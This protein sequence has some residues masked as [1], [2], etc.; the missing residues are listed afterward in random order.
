MVFDLSYGKKIYDWYGRHPLAYRIGSWIVFLGRERTLRRKGVELVGLHPGETVLDLAC[1]NGVNFELLQ[2]AV[3]AGGRIIG[4]DYSEGMLGFAAGRV[5]RAGWDNVRLVQGDAA[6]LGLPPASIDGAFCSL[7]LSAMPDHAAAIRS[8]HRELK[9]GRRFAAL[10]A[11]LFDGRAR[12]LNPLIRPI[13]KYSTN[14]NYTKDIPGAMREVFG[15]VEVH[16]F[17]GGSIFIAVGTK[18]AEPGE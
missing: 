4:F 11:R 18:S 16:R 9:P 7:G 8:V 5:E 3:G 15:S 17:N 13:F 1:G 14:W 10:D 2:D 6:R 12:F